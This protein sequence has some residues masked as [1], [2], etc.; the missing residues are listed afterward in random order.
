M[1][2]IK[3]DPPTETDV[4]EKDVKAQEK[5][6]S[7]RRFLGENTTPASDED[8][9][10]TPAEETVPQDKTEA[11]TAEAKPQEPVLTKTEVD[12]KITETKEELL[13]RIR[14][15]FG[16]TTDEEKKMADEGLIPPWEKENRTPADWKEIA[17]FGAQLAEFKRKESEAETK[18]IQDEQKQ[19][20]DNYNKQ[21]NQT[22]DMQLDELR[23]AGKLPKVNPAILAKM[24]EGRVLSEE[25]RKDPGLAAQAELF[26]TMYVVSRDR[27]SQDKPAITNM[28]EIFYEYYKPQ[29]RD[30]VA[31]EEAPISGG[32]Q[33]VDTGKEEQIDYKDLHNSDWYDLIG[34]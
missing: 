26:Q 19:Q 33:A 13:G 9:T 3:N 18:K 7:I 10:E 25:E 16:L 28:K 27:A 12:Q 29:R 11:E 22:W 14:E 5:I 4:E 23:E 1:A 21:L 30:K 31:G 20:A 8:E 2:D 17:E 6:E 15:S 24:K 32:S 34:E